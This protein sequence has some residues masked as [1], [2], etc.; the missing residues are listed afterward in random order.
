MTLLL[1]TSLWIDVTRAR[2]PAALK[3]FIAPF[4]HDPAA[5]LA[6]PVRFGL[7]DPLFARLKA[8]AA[9]R[10]IHHQQAAE[11]HRCPFGGPDDRQWLAPGEC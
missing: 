4:V 2:S 5:H 1:D 6:E 8:R 3:Q 9:R 11:K 7:P 10:H